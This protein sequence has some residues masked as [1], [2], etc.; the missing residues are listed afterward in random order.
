MMSK[1]WLCRGRGGRQE[2][3]TNSIN[4]NLVLINKSA[5]MRN[6]PVLWEKLRECPSQILSVH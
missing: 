3:Y 6:N 2:N 1:Y 4:Q 5:V